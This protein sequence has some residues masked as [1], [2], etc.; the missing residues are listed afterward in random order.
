MGDRNAST[1]EIAPVASELAGGAWVDV[2]LK[3]D[4]RGA[5]PAMPTAFAHNSKRGARIDI[6]IASST[7]GTRFSMFTPLC[8]SRC[9][10]TQ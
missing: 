7:M 5:Q 1:A 2:G 3:A 10:A 4:A 8:Q 6:V 9:R